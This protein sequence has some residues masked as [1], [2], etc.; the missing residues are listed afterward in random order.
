MPTKNYRLA[1]IGPTE[2]IS[3]LLAIGVDSFPATEH[4][5][6]VARLAEIRASETSYGCVFITESVAKTLTQEELNPKDAESLPVLL[7]IPDLH[8]DK[9]AGL[10]KLRELAK[11]A[12]GSDIFSN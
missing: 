8:S 5:D 12:I 3:G 4:D 6:A 10:D 11:R 1:A 2:L 9:N 7:T